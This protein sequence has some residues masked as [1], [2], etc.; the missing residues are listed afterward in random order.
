MVLEERKC[1][2]C[3]RNGAGDPLDKHHL[4]G[5]AYRKKSEKYGLV[6]Y[7]CH[8]RCH[9]FAPSSVHQSATTMRQLRR[10]GQLKAMR[11]QGWTTDD[12]IREFGKNYLED[13]DE[14]DAM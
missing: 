9:Q 13:G 11:E 5:G 4:I 14:A 12:F 7:L 10:Y 2:L 6:V 1:F 8:Y 3:G